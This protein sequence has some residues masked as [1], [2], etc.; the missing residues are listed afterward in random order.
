MSGLAQ[1]NALHIPF[2]DGV[3]QCI[4]TSIPYWGLR[5]YADNPP[6]VWGGDSSCVHQWLPQRYYTEKSAGQQSSAA[7]SQPGEANAERLKTARWRED[8]ACRLCGAWLGSYGLE[9]TLE[10]YLEHSVAVFREVHRVLRADGT[11]WL[12]IGDCY[13]TE[14][15]GRR[16]ADTK[17]A[18]RDD[19]TFRDKPFSTVGGGLKD[20]DLCLV[21]AR[22]A[23]ALQADRW[24]VRAENIWLKPNPLPESVRDRTTRTHEFVYMLTK[25]RRYF[26]DQESVREPAQSGPSDVRKMI[27]KLDRI[28]GKHKDLIDPLSKASAATNIGQ[29][30]AVGVPGT[31]NLRSVWSIPTQP[32]RG[33]HFATFPES[34]VDRC[35]LV[36]T[37]LFGCC[38][39][40]GAPWERVV[41]RESV[42]DLRYG[43]R[44]FD[45]ME[46]RSVYPA[47]PPERLQPVTVGWRST[48]WCGLREPVPC[49]VFDPFVG[50]GTVVQVARRHG[51]QGYGVDLSRVYLEENAL[52]RAMGRNTA[53]ALATL[54][55]FAELESR[56]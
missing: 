37:S 14:P 30:R 54:P 46:G 42:G 1:A 27:E 33:S 15:N 9:P 28:G 13:A 10:L 34:L 8:G 41:E 56:P 23:I 39:K 11:L 40:C 26:Y 21:P 2:A 24:W 3:F 51:R 16:A 17:A 5:S 50:S 55:L 32:Y 44:R 52:P 35:V 36:G 49:R 31:R 18:G 4:V 43:R 29:K 19:R 22:V 48:C 53:A 20:K 25:A 45:G 6:Q 7:F 47:M 38:P 12:N